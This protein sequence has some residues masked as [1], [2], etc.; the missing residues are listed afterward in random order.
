MLSRTRVQIVASTTR[1]RN[2]IRM[3]LHQ[4]GLIDPNDQRVLSRKIV[5]DVLGRGVSPELQMSVEI[6][7]S[8]WEALLIG[9]RRLEKEIRDQAEADPI[10]TVWHS[11]PG[12]GPISSR[13]M[14]DELGD[15]SQFPNER[16]LF[17]Y[18]GLTPG[19]YSTGSNVRRGHISRQGNP[20][21]RQVLVEAAWRAIRQDEALRKDFER[22]AA[23]GGKKKIAIVAIARLNLLTSTSSV[24]S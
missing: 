6:L 22:I 11:L 20:R 13:S 8:N 4:F 14:A 24:S 1:T 7:L 21:L 10:Q 2:Q 15:M 12:F 17:R 16:G 9:K 23:R 3:K 5:K 19:E 18:T